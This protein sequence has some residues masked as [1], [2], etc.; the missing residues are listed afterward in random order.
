[1]VVTFKFEGRG[2]LLTFKNHL[3]TAT[4]RAVLNTGDCR[5]SY[6]HETGAK[7]GGYRHTH[8]LAWYPN[9][10][11]T[12]NCRR[13]DVVSNGGLIHPNIQPIRTKVHWKNCLK[14]ISK[15]NELQY[16][17]LDG[18]EWEKLGTAGML[19]R[20]HTS[21]RA[22]LQDAYLEETVKKHLN[23]AREVFNHRPK[24]K[25][26]THD[27]LRPWQQ[28]AYDGLLAQDD[29]KITWVVGEEGGE[30]KTH[31][32]RYIVDRGGFY[33]RG[34]KF[35]DIAMR[36]DG[37]EVVCLDLVRSSEDFT[38]YKLI[39]NMKDGIVES[40]KYTSCAKYC[41][42]DGVLCATKLIVFANYWP[43]ES[44]MSSDRWHVVSLKNGVF[45]E[46]GCLNIKD[47]PPKSQAEKE[48]ITYL[49]SEF[50][51]KRESRVNSLLREFKKG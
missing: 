19:I 3:T 46:T 37:E 9:K 18:S 48:P 33:T 50:S 34:G 14:Y 43:D 27:K 40:G 1:M 24:P 45:H 23:W 8:C 2:L 21:W 28:E 17:G 49:L 32:G 38:P 5:F 12:T 44:K 30:G 39:E 4:L 41:V 22:V 31:L 47:I 7:D 36:Y 35:A 11:H 20:A 26:F 13:W 25:M 6:C 15:E 29:R 16:D 51:K 10:T 42:K